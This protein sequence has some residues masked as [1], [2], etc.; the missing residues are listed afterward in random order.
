MGTSMSVLISMLFIQ[1]SKEWFHRNCVA[2]FSQLYNGTKGYLN[3][4]IYVDIEELPLSVCNWSLFFA[5]VILK[6][7]IPKRSVCNGCL[8]KVGTECSERHGRSRTKRFNFSPL[9][10]KSQKVRK[11]LLDMLQKERSDKYCKV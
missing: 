6:I 4:E 7:Y 1:Y 10:R 11:Y 2:I 3:V 5:S 9:S 8:R